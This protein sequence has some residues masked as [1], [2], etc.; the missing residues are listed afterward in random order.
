MEAEALKRIE[1]LT[2]ASRADIETDI[3]S[4]V[5]PGGTEVRSLEKLMDRPARMRQNYETVRIPDF[6]RY[7]NESASKQS[8]DS[9]VYVLPDGSAATAMIDHGTVSEPLWGDH[10]AHLSLAETRAFTAMKSLCARHITNQTLIDYLEDWGDDGTDDEVAG[11]V[12]YRHGEV[13]SL[14]R[15]IAAIRRVEIK[16]TSGSTHEVHDFAAS[17]S[18][19]SDIEAKGS[20]ETMPTHLVINAPVYVGTEPREIVAK[21][22]IVPRDDE[23]AFRLRMLRF[24]S[25][26]EAVAAEVEE[27]LRNEL[28]G[29]DVFVGEASRFG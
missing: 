10:K 18:A 4:V 3:P 11:V 26:Q 29:I 6:V 14:G 13:V 15:A 8:G 19:F 12:A 21:I 2:A 28:H 7:V 23:P 5:L 22:G 27:R 20:E 17:K 1:E 25:I 16:S 24:E 9:A